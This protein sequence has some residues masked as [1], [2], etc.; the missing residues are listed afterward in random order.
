MRISA[1]A[2]RAALVAAIAATAGAAGAQDN[3]PLPQDPVSPAL[4][5]ERAPT[6]IQRERRRDDAR[7]MDGS[8]NNLNDPEMG[9]AN[10]QL[11]RLMTPGYADS[12]SSMAGAGR[13]SPREISNLVVAET[14]QRLNP[15]GASD[16][17][18]QWGQF[19]DHD[20]DLTN[21]TDPPEPA[22]ILVPKGDPSFDPSGTGT[23]TIGLNRSLY[24]HATG[25]ST[26][27]PRQQINEI[28]GWIDGSQVYGSSLERAMALRANDGTGHLRT[29]AGNLL[30]FNDL[31]LPNAG[32]SSPALFL[33]GDERVN[34]QVGLTAM[35]T[36]FM[37]EHN[38]LADQTAR[39]H[40]DW[41]DERI[42]QKAREL[43]GAE[44]QVITYREFLPALLG[45]N[46]LPSYQGYRPG[47]DA[48]IANV[49]STAAYRFG[50]SALSPTLLRLDANGATIA[51]GNLPLRDAFFAPQH[52]V[53]EGGIEPILRG[54]AA[55]QMRR[56]DNEIVDDVRNFLFGPPGAGGFDLASLNIQRGRDHGLP[57]YNEVRVAFGLPAAASFADV[58]SDVRQ[59]QRL[60]SAYATVDDIDLWVGG[61]AE[62][63]VGGGHVGPLVRRILAR[64]FAALRDGD[65]FWYARTLSAAEI[66]M[67]EATRLS[68]IIRRNTTIG[69]ELQGNVFRARAPGG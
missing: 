38:R 44:I 46:A 27:A 19:I 62:D 56:V 22:P 66:R 42:Y 68:D 41:D 45:P 8:G 10:T 63:R 31:G 26:T 3:V 29:S 16:Y 32:G 59:Q 65:R 53:D 55:Q 1:F 51:A 15:L 64:Q 23:A 28:T 20:I 33:A 58:T 48:R 4:R 14:A 47:V 24:D 39:A 52:I 61:L 67:V 60:A 50:H 34:E 2:I 13:K 35:H 9:A 69:A 30:P 12:I 18:W 6:E 54:L 7:T 11:R 21:G 25:T 17:L 57:S 40:P 36:L 5:I 43:V 49:F 37:R